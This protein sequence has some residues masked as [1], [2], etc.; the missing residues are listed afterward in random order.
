MARKRTGVLFGVYL[1]YR[2]ELATGLIF[3]RGLVDF[4]VCDSGVACLKSEKLCRP[5]TGTGRSRTQCGMYSCKLL[6]ISTLW[7]PRGVGNCGLGI[8][9]AWYW[10][11]ERQNCVIE[12]TKFA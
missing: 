7:E 1:Y 2:P 9:R 6:I 5:R 10:F 11:A 3:T 8:L 4:G 12:V